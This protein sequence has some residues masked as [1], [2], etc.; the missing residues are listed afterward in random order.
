MG[1]LFMLRPI[2]YQFTTWFAV[3]LQRT[4]A[5]FVGLVSDGGYVRLP[6]I[7]FAS[8]FLCFVFPLLLATFLFFDTHIN[9]LVR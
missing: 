5:S 2:V 1:I 7:H 6:I 8:F 9:L 4:V 3:P